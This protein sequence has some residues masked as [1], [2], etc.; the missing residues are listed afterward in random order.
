V[1]AALS[2]LLG[3]EVAVWFVVVLLVDAA[4]LVEV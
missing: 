1:L 3:V 4:L 2:L